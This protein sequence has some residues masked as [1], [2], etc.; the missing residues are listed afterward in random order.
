[1]AFK[2]DCGASTVLVCSAWRAQPGSSCRENAGRPAHPRWSGR[3]P[4]C[5]GVARSAK[6]EGRSRTG[7]SNSKLKTKNSKLFRGADG[8][9]IRNSKS[10]I[11]NSWVET[12][13]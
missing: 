3:S 7:A 13:N 4:T 11:R 10:E 12:Q 6:P 9:K 8:W 5:H 2:A 1:M